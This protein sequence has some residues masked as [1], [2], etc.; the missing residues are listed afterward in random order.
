PAPRALRL[1]SGIWTGRARPRGRADRQ[2]PASVVVVGGLG[3]RRIGMTPTQTGPGELKSGEIKKAIRKFW[4]NRPCGII[5]SWQPAGGHA[6]FRETEEHRFRIHTDW[7][8]PFLKE[9]IG[10]TQHT[11]KQVLEIGCGIGVDALEWSKAGNRVVGLDYNFP[12][13]EVTR[14]RFRDAGHSGVFLNGDA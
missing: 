2:R 5:H 9:A 11:G 7:D 10:F 14:T 3:I 4:G 8:R 13:C 1:F 12:S 6:F